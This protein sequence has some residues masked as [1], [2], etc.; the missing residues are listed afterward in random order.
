MSQLGLFISDQ[1]GGPMSDLLKLIHAYGDACFRCGEHVDDSEV[2][3]DTVLAVKRL[4]LGNLIEAIK[5]RN[6]AAP[7][8]KRCDR[9]SAA[10]ERIMEICRDER[11]PSQIFEI[12][13]EALIEPEQEAKS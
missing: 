4:A 13:E 6:D 5:S 10:L 1:A 12:A 11:L 7:Y 8:A 3:Y 9:F 2:S